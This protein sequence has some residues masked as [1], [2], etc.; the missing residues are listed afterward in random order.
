MKRETAKDNSGARHAT[1]D[2][3]YASERKF[4]A[5]LGQTI[6][7]AMSACSQVLVRQEV[8][9]LSASRRSVHNF[10]GCEN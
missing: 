3:K 1:G 7:I 5:L 6:E 10:F 2:M 9:P 8:G 4:C